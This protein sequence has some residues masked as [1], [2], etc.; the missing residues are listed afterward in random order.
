MFLRRIIPGSKLANSLALQERVVSVRRT[1]KVVTGGRLFTFSVFIVVG[2]GNGNF[3]YG[4]GKAR[5]VSIA[6]K[7]A[8]NNAKKKLFSV[9]MRGKRT[10]AHTVHGTCTSSTIMIR[11][12]Q[13]GT[14][15][16]AGGAAKSLLEVIGFKDVVAKCFGS[17]ANGI[18]VV[19]A[20]IDALGQ[21]CSIRTLANL[22][23]KSPLKI[24]NAKP[25]EPVIQS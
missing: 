4:K 22:R 17:S 9:S 8:F 1:T 19:L 16:I 20:T 10:I 12:A 21:L 7:K 14:G 5:E 2:D 11:P 15:V 13:P 6:R 24:I 23:G 25:E 3:G 18:S